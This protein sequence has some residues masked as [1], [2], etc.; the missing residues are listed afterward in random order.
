MKSI[1]Y[2]ENQAT[3][4]RCLAALALPV[5]KTTIALARFDERLR[6]V[7]PALAE[8][9]RARAHV[10][11]A[12]A[13]VGLSGGFAP[14]EHL[15]LHDSNMPIQLATLDVVKAGSWLALRRSLARRKPDDVLAADRVAE[16]IAIRSA[17][18]EDAVDDEPGTA[19]KAR[20][21]VLT[22]PGNGRRSANPWDM[23]RFGGD[24]EDI[25]DG[26]DR[27]EGNAESDET[28]DPLD[29]AD[30][31]AGPA[32]ETN[33]DTTSVSAEIDAL[34]LP[35]RRTLG[36]YNDVVSQAGRNE[37]QLADPECDEAGRLAEWLR[38]FNAQ[39]SA[40]AVVAA[41]IA[42]DAWLWLQ[43]SQRQGEAGFMLAATVL[44]QREIAS[45]HLPTLASGLRHRRYRWHGWQAI[46]IR[47][48][49]LVDAIT[50]SAQLGHADL[51]RLTNARAAMM[52]RC[53]GKSKNS[54]LR[55]L[56]DLF[57]S[58]PLVTIQ[59]ASAALKVSPQGID[60][61]LAE[62][63]SSLPRELTGRKRYRA[64]GIVS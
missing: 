9:F 37:I 14:L 46:E 63:G 26:A 3:T 2:D 48:T 19:G 30:D 42:L 47:L 62:L 27:G 15:V 31:P 10:F 29:T 58:N 49:G 35:T 11:E 52:R 40:P 32:Q 16:L 55:D 20:E 23:P 45:L 33:S 13:L 18:R 17:G 34:I 57:A 51:D 41:S 8:G 21:P 50:G 60:V 36:A 22:D 28:L 12:Q 39:A 4:P 54:R 24:D 64:W 59:M 6:R 44:R 38:V 1:R 43:P 56:V 25:E 5:E 61:M 53:V 7:E